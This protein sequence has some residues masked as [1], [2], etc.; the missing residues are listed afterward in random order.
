MAASLVNSLLAEPAVADPPRRV[1]RDWALLAVMVTTVVVEAFVNDAASWRPISTVVVVA[2]LSTLMW[3]RTHPLTVMVINFGVVLVAERIAQVASGEPFEYY[4][5]AF[6]L[7]AP[8]A[9]FRWGSGRHAAIGLGIMLATLVSALHG[10][11]T[12]LGDAIGGTLVLLFPAV[13]GLEVRNLVGSRERDREEVKL[14][15]RE[16]LA[17]ELHDTV[18]HHVSAIAIR[19]QAGRVVG[20][21]DPDAALDALVVIEEEASR[22]LAEMRG[23]VGTLRGDARAEFAPQPQLTDLH[24]LATGPREPQDGDGPRVEVTVASDVGDVGPTVGGA[25]YRMAQE[26]I[27]NARRH[28]RSATIVSVDVATDGEQ[29]LLRVDDDGLDTTAS[30]DGSGGFGIVGMTER[31]HLLGGTLTAGPNADRGWRVAASIPRQAVGS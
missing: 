31:A 29:I 11:W 10:D 30:A 26:A 3:R 24:R 27:T 28:A 16:L 13:L 25:L 12:G 7:L 14:R 6:L 23:I 5:A 18:A 9:L 19:A 21:N 15:E 8:Y 1:W 4:S 17:R 20:A 22:T 2:M